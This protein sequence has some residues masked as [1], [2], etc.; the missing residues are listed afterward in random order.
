MEI[1]TNFG[2][3]LL[4]SSLRLIHHV[5]SS[6][7]DLAL[8][9]SFHMLL[10][11]IP[12]AALIQSGK[13]NPAEDAVISRENQLTEYKLVLGRTHPK[14]GLLVQDIDNME[15]PHDYS[16][17]RKE[18]LNP[19]DDVAPGWDLGFDQFFDMDALWPLM[20]EWANPAM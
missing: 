18:A 16:R 13:L 10:A 12:L 11:L 4:F 17:F 9:P 20:N 8:V 5:L 7:I 1:V 14:L 6:Q 3:Q 2:G 19:L 15:P